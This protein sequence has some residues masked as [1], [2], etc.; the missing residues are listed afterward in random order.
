MVKIPKCATNRVIK[1]F[2]LSLTVTTSS[3]AHFQDG[4]EETI[5]L[6]QKKKKKTGVSLWY[7]GRQLE[8]MGGN[9]K[10]GWKEEKQ[11][12]NR[13][14]MIKNKSLTER[15]NRETKSWCRRYET[16]QKWKGAA[17]WEPADSAVGETTESKEITGT[18]WTKKKRL[19][20]PKWEQREVEKKGKFQEEDWLYQK[21][22]NRTNI[23][24]TP[25]T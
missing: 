8:R 6:M 24:I 15:D 13:G 22:K 2:L 14:A 17:V 5:S 16:P 18:A 9:E 4:Q 1:G 20:S 23:N 19:V 7:E 21:L 11:T 10:W 12:G 3:L 25:L